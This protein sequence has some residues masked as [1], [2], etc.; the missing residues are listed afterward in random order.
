ME[1]TEEWVFV[2]EFG[3]TVFAAEAPDVEDHVV[4]AQSLHR[5]DGLFA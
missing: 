1:G 2:P 4:R 3:V 5:V